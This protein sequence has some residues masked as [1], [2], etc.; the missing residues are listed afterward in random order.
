MQ[1]NFSSA[2]QRVNTLTFSDGSQ[3]DSSKN[4]TEEVQFKKRARFADE[5]TLESDLIVE[6]VIYG[7][8]ADLDVR[9]KEYT[10]LR[11]GWPW[12]VKNPDGETYDPNQDSLGHTLISLKKHLMLRKLM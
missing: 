2:N 6:G 7:T 10:D 9:S 12:P 4:L 8:L 1:T 5:T 3:I 11:T